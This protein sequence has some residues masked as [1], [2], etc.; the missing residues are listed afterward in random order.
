MAGRVH[1]FGAPQRSGS[2]GEHFLTDTDNVSGESPTVRVCL[3]TL[4]MLRQIKAQPG[5]ALY[6]SAVQRKA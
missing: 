5:V 2:S 6:P 1:D 3:P 4:L